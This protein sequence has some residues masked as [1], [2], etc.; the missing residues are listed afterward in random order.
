MS[1]VVVG[2]AEQIRN[3]LCGPPQHDEHCKG[4][5]WEMYVQDNEKRF[6][7]V[8]AELRKIHAERRAR[9]AFLEAAE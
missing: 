9:E 5:R 7:N 6:Q 8:M 2:S 1:F 3:L 4:W